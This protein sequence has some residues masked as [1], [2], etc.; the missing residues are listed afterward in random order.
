MNTAMN[1][2]TNWWQRW[3]RG[4]ALEETL[5]GFFFVSPFIVGFL[6]FIAFPMAYSFLLSLYHWDLLTPARFVGLSNILKMLHDPKVN[7]SLYNSAF[8]TIFAVPLQLVFSFMLAMALT[9]AIK[10]RAFYRAGFYMPFI[11]P[12]VASA[13]VW[14]RVFHP[15]YGLLNDVI[16]WF[17]IPPQKWLWDPGLAK[18]AFILMSCWFIGRQ[19]VIFIAG[20]QNIPESLLEAASID[21]AGTFHKIFHII[22][23]LMT[24]LIF[25][26]MITAIINSFQIFVPALL[27]TQGGP[28]DATLFAVLNIYRNGFE[29]FNMGYASALAWEFFVIIIGFTV[30][31]FYLSKRWVY[32]EIG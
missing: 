13:V 23:P 11:V 17:G 24:P 32:Y 12:L 6:A 3:F 5:W 20:L 31:Q 18:P 9:Q 10:G 30:A 7:L 8:F 4:L 19:M 2:I 27:M 16:A 28:Q 14:Q 26:N 22:I 1:L 25:Y 15:E 29:Y 21:G